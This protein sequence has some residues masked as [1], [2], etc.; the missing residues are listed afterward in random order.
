MEMGKHD[1][2]T[3][4][5]LNEAL[6]LHYKDRIKIL[7]K[8]LEKSTAKIKDAMMLLERKDIIIAEKDAYIEELR[9]A[10]I[11]ATLR[12]NRGGVR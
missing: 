5:T 12:A 11:E 6:E 2:K 3:R 4:S 7:E 9:S 10:F 8:Q 1:M